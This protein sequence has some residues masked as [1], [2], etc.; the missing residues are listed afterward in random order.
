ME[1]Y[2]HNTLSGKTEKFKPI[3]KE[4]G[5]YS[6]GPTVYSEQHIGNMR[7]MLLADFVKRVLIFNK[8]KV[9]HVMNYTDVGHLT[10]ND[11]GEDKVESFAKKHGKNVKEITGH[12]IN[13]FEDDLKKLNYIF[14]KFVKA[15][16]HIEEQ[17]K[18]IKKLEKKGYT[19]L[20]ADGVYFDTS[21]MK[22]YGKLA[23]FDKM[24]RQAGKRVSLGGK[25]N[26]T[27]F[28]LW[29]FSS[30]SR[31]QEW[32]SPWGKGFPGWHIECSAMAIKYLGE[33]FDIH[34]GG[35]DL[36][37]VHH[38]N[39]IAQSEC[40]TGEKFVNY[41]IHGAFLNFD[42]EKMSKSKGG[43]YTVSDLEEQGYIPEHLRYLF[44]LTHYRKPLNFT[45]ENLDSARNAFEKLK[46]KI[47]ELR[48]MDVKG[49]DG[50]GYEKMFLESVNNDLNF[51]EA[52]QVMHKM[53][54]DNLS[55][56]AKLKLLYSFDEVFGLGLKE[57]KEER[58][59][60]EVRKLVIEREKAR[61][62]KNW[63]ESDRLRNEI[64]ALG[65]EV[66]DSA[67]GS[68]VRKR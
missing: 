59:P 53:L 26:V 23:G 35:Q 22:N 2:L 36:S 13:K 64:R 56:K 24:Q 32:D 40:A 1:I 33:H 7:T 12:C 68:V 62:N 54:D 46:R 31:L 55:S 58:I 5:M 4:V 17:I 28:A 9:K 39:E 21:K 37:Q 25:R 6:C 65:Y 48:E 19:Y 43:F 29:K 38:N 3:G 45:F 27:D 61:K 11:V 60:E 8:Y 18:L 20:T 30:E 51:P 52:V 34:T 66:E 67:E 41:W 50:K 57:I 42:G 49:N 10:E 14:P 63:K 16:D 47:L 15:T 44:L